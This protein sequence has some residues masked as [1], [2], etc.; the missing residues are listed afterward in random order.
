[1]KVMKY[2]YDKKMDESY[3]RSLI[4]SFK[5]TIDDYLFKF[6]IVDMINKNLNQIDEMSNYA[7]IKGFQTY[8]IDLNI[9]DSKFCFERNTHKRTLNEIEKVLKLI[10][11]R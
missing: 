2:E 4:K 10:F 8:I 7:K 9:Y 11:D 3:Q 1:M 6:I 5:K